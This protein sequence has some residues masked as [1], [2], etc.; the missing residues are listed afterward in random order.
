MTTTKSLKG[1]KTE[2][3]LALAYTAESMAYTRYMFYAQQANKDG[4]PPIAI[5]FESTANN[6]MHHSKVFFKYLPGGK[7]SNEVTIDSGVIG[8]TAENLAMSANEELHEGVELYTNAAKV[9]REEGFEEIAGVFDSI[10]KVEMFHRER[11]LKYLDMVQK[12]TVYKREK[13]IVWQCL[14]CGYVY[15]GAEPPVKCPACA[16]PRKYYMDV[17]E[18][19]N[20]LVD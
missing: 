14:V 18:M 7:A 3:N 8:T 5:I 11:F 10:A 17:A 1:T 4:F 15:E 20:Y 9:A 13:P 16:H 19:T 2:A 6:E 12:G